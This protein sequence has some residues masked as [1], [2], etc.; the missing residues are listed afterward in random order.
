MSAPWLFTQNS[1]PRSA[2]PHE[3]ITLA[4][5]EEPALC[6]R[7]CGKRWTFVPAGQ[8]P[9]YCAD[10]DP[11]YPGM[12]DNRGWSKTSRVVMAGEID[13]VAENEVTRWAVRVLEGSPDVMPGTNYDATSV[14]LNPY[15]EEQLRR[16]RKLLV[17]AI[18]QFMAKSHQAAIAQDI[19]L[20]HTSQEIRDEIIA[21]VGMMADARTPEMQARYDAAVARER[22]PSPS[23]DNIFITITGSQSSENTMIARAVLEL[24]QETAVPCSM[25]EETE[26]PY[27]GDSIE[28]LGNLRRR[29]GMR[30]IVQTGG[31]S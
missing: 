27:D 23:H 18:L 4:N 31:A 1:T 6:C 29:P 15:A 12:L 21:K 16:G 28:Q 10:D 19:H 20:G 14:S 11:T 22:A 2:C 17:D 9:R 5:D 13:P 26:N 7:S 3:Q 25:P 30:V 8:I 24:L